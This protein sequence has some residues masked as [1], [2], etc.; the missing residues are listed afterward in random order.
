MPFTKNFR[1]PSQLT[2]AARGAFDAAF[3]KKNQ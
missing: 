1:T 3:D 2:G